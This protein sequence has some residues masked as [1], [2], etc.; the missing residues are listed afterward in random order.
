MNSSVAVLRPNSSLDSSYFFRW[1]TSAYIQSVI[2]SFK[3]GQGVPHLFQADIR[4]FSLLRPP[5]AEQR[6]IAAFLD[7]E[8]A[9][10]D[11]LIVKMDEAVKRLQEYRTALITSA[12]TGKT[13]VREEIDAPRAILEDEESVLEA[14][15]R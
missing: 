1:L 14:A 12:V 6:A 13:D 2:Q 10:L 3:D 11:T 9:R 7:R 4:K 8:T 5:L 15:H